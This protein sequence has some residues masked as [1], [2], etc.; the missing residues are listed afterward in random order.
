MNIYNLSKINILKLLVFA[1]LT[2]FKHHNAMEPEQNISNSPEHFKSLQDRSLAIVLQYLKKADVQ[3]LSNLDYLNRI[4]LAPKISQYFGEKALYH[5]IQPVVKQ[6]FA[7]ESVDSTKAY[8]TLEDLISFD[9]QTLMATGTHS[10]RRFR[11][12]QQDNVFQERGIT[13]FSIGSCSGLVG[14]EDFFTVWNKNH[15]KTANRNGVYRIYDLMGKNE[16]VGIAQNDTKD[17]QAF[18]LRPTE[19]DKSENRLY[20]TPNT[21]SKNFEYSSTNEI[22]IKKSIKAENI[23]VAKNGKTV[24]ME[25]AKT[26]EKFLWRPQD[27]PEKGIS[28][29]SSISGRDRLLDASG[30]YILTL[31]NRSYKEPK[32]IIKLWKITSENKAKVV[33]ST[34]YEGKKFSD[35]FVAKIFEKDG[36]PAGIITRGKSSSELAISILT[37]YPKKLIDYCQPT[38]AIFLY[39]LLK[40]HKKQQ[41]LIPATAL[42]D[43]LQNDENFQYLQKCFDSL[44]EKE[45]ISP[46]TFK[47]TFQLPYQ[48]AIFK[49]GKESQTTRRVE[50]MKTTS[51]PFMKSNDLSLKQLLSSLH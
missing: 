11:L 44:V 41:R 23:I 38:E 29:L 6:T 7:L 46:E 2:L 48:G 50:T 32:H 33:F 24:V 20:I 4:A 14:S 37:Q 51:I 40:T 45:I 31:S 34:P 17:Q 39:H 16:L 9:G 19:N 36:Q 21:Y 47:N 1:G 27:R 30:E 43:A 25:D 13:P 35:A 42:E 10:T 28:Y 8:I 5:G 12:N 49:S 18:I 22:N 3:D 15:F 26:G